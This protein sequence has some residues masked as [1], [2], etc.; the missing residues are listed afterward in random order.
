MVENIVD[1]FTLYL[2]VWIVSGLACWAIANSRKSTPVSWFVVGLL[3]GPFGVLLTLA[4][5]KPVR[6]V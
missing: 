4:F 5:A 1:N 2:I 6:E 3:L